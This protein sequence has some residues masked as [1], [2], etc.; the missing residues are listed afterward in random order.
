MVPVLS[1]TPRSNLGR[2]RRE[3]P[4]LQVVG[5]LLKKTRGIT[6]PRVP[7]LTFFYG[8]EPRVSV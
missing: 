2:G 6:L 5:G 7:T 1:L 8:T 4:E 3:F